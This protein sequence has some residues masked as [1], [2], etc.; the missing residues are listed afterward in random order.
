MGDEAATALAALASRYGLGSGQLAQ[1]QRLLVTLSGDP[2][3]PTAIADEQR[4]VDEHLADSLTGLEL[5]G[6]AQAGAIADIGSGAGL[7]GLALAVALPAVVVTLVESVA[8]KCLFLEDAARAIGAANVRVA[9]SRAEE[10]VADL[11]VDAVTARALA[12][13]P[14]VLEYAAPLLRVGGTLVDWRGAREE[15]EEQAAGRAAAELGLERVAV[16][17]VVP[18]AGARDRHLHEF[19]KV[20]NTPDRFPRRPGMAR[21]RPLG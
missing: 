14:V 6:L 12:P 8:R 2:H 1:M 15:A 17:S 5:P 4:I 7:P 16:H 10:W 11:P 13:Q 19:A 20:A 3:A 21:K 9:C 18:F